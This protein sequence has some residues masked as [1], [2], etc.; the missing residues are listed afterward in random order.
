MHYTCSSTLKTWSWQYDASGNRVSESEDVSSTY[1][2]HNNLNQLDQIGGA[3]RT[4]VEG[5]VDE[6]AF[7]KINGQDAIVLSQP[8]G[9]F[10]FRK[11]IA[12]TEGSNTII[13]EATDAS[14]NRASNTY[15]IVVGGVQKTL[16]YDLNGNL[17][18]EKNP[19]GGT[20]LREFQWDAKN[21]LLAFQNVAIGSEVN[22]SKR[23]EFTYDGMDRRVRI[24]EKT[25]NGIS[26]ASDSNKVFVWE[27]AQIVQR[28]DSAGATIER[29]YF[30]DGF[31]EGTSDY[32][33][34][35]DHLGSIREVV[36]SNG[37]TIE[38][39]YD[40]SPWGQVTK[41]V[42]SGVESDFLYT[43]HLYHDESDLHLTLYRAY[44]S[45]L[46][47]WLSRDPIAENGGINLYAYVGNDPIN[48]FDPLG[49]QR[50]RVGWN[51]SNRSRCNA[52]LDSLGDAWDAFKETT[53]GEFGVGLGLGVKGN[54]GPVKGNLGVDA[55]LSQQWNLNGQSSTVSQGN[56]GGSVGSGNHSVGLNYGGSA[57]VGGA[58]GGGSSSNTVVGY[59]NNTGSASPSS[60]GAS[61]TFGV[62]RV[63][64]SF[65]PGAIY[66]ALFPKKEEKDCE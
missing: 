22:G 65:D 26:W 45:E 2:Q 29:N 61:G 55:S 27:G 7:V 35:R 1:T 6:P 38:A 17:R 12:V 9:D 30:A 63:G 48:W 16:E 53:T 4:L 59:S 50:P 33:Y 41:T 52:S 43:G 60:V 39:V 20:V 11:E 64:A 23:S 37:T 3:G 44:N 13:V 42:G 24:V 34:T 57:Y 62:I 8:R 40:Y 58:D 18:F 31:E 54:L 66:D 25:H 19:S 5:V 28:R 49:L 46:G 56:V 47:M 15:S 21:R 36:A 14:G 51:P 10:L 32:F